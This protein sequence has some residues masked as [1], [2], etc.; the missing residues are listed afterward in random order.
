MNLWNF[1]QLQ[2]GSGESPHH[3]MQCCYVYAKC[4]KIIKSNTGG[5]LKRET[6]QDS[7]NLCISFCLPEIASTIA[8]FTAGWPLGDCPYYITPA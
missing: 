4:S 6:G 2:S 7:Y 1:L 3:V 5:V 8:V